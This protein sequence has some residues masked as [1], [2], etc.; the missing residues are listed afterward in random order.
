MIGVINHVITLVKGVKLMEMKL[1]MKKKKLLEIIKCNKKLQKKLNLSIKDYKEY[2]Q[3]YSSIEIELKLN[4]NEHDKKDTFI[5]IS[6][7]DK[8]YFRIYFNNSNKETKRNYL[9]KMR[10]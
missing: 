10:L 7:K 9:K 1:I 2:S 5:N 6:T 8:K 3:L 4:D